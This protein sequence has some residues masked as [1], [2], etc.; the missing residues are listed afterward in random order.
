MMVNV[1]CLHTVSCC[2]F[3]KRNDLVNVLVNSYRCDEFVVN[4][5]LSGVIDSIRQHILH[6]STLYVD[7]LL[8]C[9][10][11]FGNIFCS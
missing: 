2:C 5:T 3:D 11:A 8:C 4:D 1:Y 7:H 6:S 9:L 10:L